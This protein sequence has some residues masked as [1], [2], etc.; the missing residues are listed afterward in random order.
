MT[1]AG[2]ALTS[3]RLNPRKL[4]LC[5]Y[6]VLT[7]SR[8]G[9]SESATR[10]QKNFRVK[11][12]RV[13]DPDFDYS[14]LNANLKIRDLEKKFIEMKTQMERQVLQIIEENPKRIMQHL[15]TIEEKET[16]LWA[17]NMQR[18][19][20]N[21]ENLENV[22]MKQD[23]NMG[24]LQKTLM[25]MKREIE[26][27]N[28]KNIELRRNM[29]SLAGQSKAAFQDNILAIEDKQSQSS[30]VV[31][32]QNEI[33]SMKEQMAANQQNKNDFFKD[34]MSQ[35]QNMND[36]ILRNE[37]EYFGRLR[38]QKD[39]ISRE[40]V[41]QKNQFKNLEAVRMEK[42]LGDNEYVKG[43]VDS[44]DRRVKDEIQKRIAQEFD[45]KQWMERQ[46]KVFKDEVVSFPTIFY[47]DSNFVQRK[48]TREKS[49]QT[50]TDSL[51]KSRKLYPA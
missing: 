15:R 47:P 36:M 19:N 27:L 4:F 50:K 23:N 51:R 41:M 38:D 35:Y 22:K 21:F 45:S 26:D 39:E 46:L 48:T 8:D 24:L 32:L 31:S 44:L 29:E 25:D 13:G 6:Q 1:S 30:T 40:Q 16:N 34:M 10:S 20:K 42:L 7:L 2:V 28:F 11:R 9:F 17:E 3:R 5:Q 18:H 43:L 49:L 37:K 12:P 33:R 14:H